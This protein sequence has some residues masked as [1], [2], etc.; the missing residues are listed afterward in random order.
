MS[1]RNWARRKWSFAD[2]KKTLNVSENISGHKSKPG[3]PDERDDAEASR[4]RKMI[5][6]DP[7]KKNYK[8]VLMA[9]S[10]DIQ[11]EYK[12]DAEALLELKVPL[13]FRQQAALNGL[14]LDERQGKYYDSES[15]PTVRSLAK[16]KFD[17]QIK[18]RSLQVTEA[19]E[20]IEQFKK[21]NSFSISTDKNSNKFRNQRLLLLEHN[22]NTARADLKLVKVSLDAYETKELIKCENDY[23]KYIAICFSMI[24]H[25]TG[26]CTSELIQSVRSNPDYIKAC[27]RGDIVQVGHIIKS[28]VMNTDS[29]NILD[30]RSRRSEDLKNF[31]FVPGKM[32]FLVFADQISKKYEEFAETC[33]DGI[34]PISEELSFVRSI[35]QNTRVIF[36]SFTNSWLG[37]GSIDRPTSVTNLMKILKNKDRELNLSTM[38]V[39]G[40]PYVFQQSNYSPNG[41]SVNIIKKKAFPITGSSTTDTKSIMCRNMLKNKQ[42]SYGDLCKFN[43]DIQGSS[44]KYKIESQ[45]ELKSMNSEFCG[46]M[47]RTGNCQYGE[48]C[49]NAS[50]HLVSCQKYAQNIQNKPGHLE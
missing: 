1:N 21:E 48:K 33:Q 17:S 36:W 8:S 30:E 19:M 20:E 32:K 47:M 44:K 26:M 31:A 49:R 23:T 45:S 28:C 22:L 27:Q 14:W 42:C 38:D 35:I 39:T 43:H 40:L 11:K 41:T 34:V 6:I 12:A 16:C 2:R 4:M 37:E 5:K 50:K 9:H 18:E 10:G 3:G 7:A 15:V 24:G 25:L 46:F 13:V 29:T